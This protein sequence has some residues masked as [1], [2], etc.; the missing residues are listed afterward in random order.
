[1]NGWSNTKTG[2]DVFQTVHVF[3]IHDS[4]N[5]TNNSNSCRMIQSQEMNRIFS[6]VIHQNIG[7]N[8]VINIARYYLKIATRYIE[9]TSRKSSY[10]LYERKM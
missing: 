1:M 7:N 9:T 10:R 4:M 6:H 5:R 3:R 8:N 2:Y